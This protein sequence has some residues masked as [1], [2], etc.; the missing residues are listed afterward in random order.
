MV[1]CVQLSPATIILL[2]EPL[3][4]ASSEVVRIW[5]VRIKR[6]VAKVPSGSERWKG[7]L[8]IGGGDPFT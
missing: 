5:P 6:V 4:L 1:E 7:P 8:R 3:H 2:C